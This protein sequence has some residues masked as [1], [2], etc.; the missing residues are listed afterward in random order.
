MGCPS[1]D[2]HA[3]A[4]RQRQRGVVE[5]STPNDTAGPDISRA[6][7]SHGYTLRRG[8]G[9]HHH[10]RHPLG[11]RVRLVRS[12]VRYPRVVPTVARQMCQRRASRRGRFAPAVAV[13]AA[14]T[15]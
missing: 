6:V 11:L 12:P 5:A 14:V 7:H 1:S 3:G 13:M 8:S 2:P 9:P 15:A 4:P 10:L